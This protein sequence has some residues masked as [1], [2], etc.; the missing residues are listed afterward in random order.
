MSF[1]KESINII[2]AGLTGLSAAITLARAGRN[3]NLIS[4]LPSERAQSAIS[5]Q[6]LFI[7]FLRLKNPSPKVWVW[8][9]QPMP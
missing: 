1:D 2:G 5:L 4:M 7:R 3:C 6:I 8:A 9:P